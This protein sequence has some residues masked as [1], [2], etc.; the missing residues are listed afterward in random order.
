METPPIVDL[1]GPPFEKGLAH[2]RAFAD[3]VARSLDTY[4]HLFQRRRGLSWN[5]ARAIARRFAPVFSGGAAP[6]A[7]EMR[8]IAEGAGRT[9][10]DILA[11]KAQ[12]K[13]G[14]VV[15]ILPDPV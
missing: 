9:F 1:A 13:V 6:L 15:I 4:A 12:V 2:G 3:K 14:T 10:E 11:L 8:G 7:E 5:D